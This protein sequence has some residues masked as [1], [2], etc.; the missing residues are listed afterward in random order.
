M[1]NLAWKT[2]NALSKVQKGRLKRTPK[3]TLALSDP[4]TLR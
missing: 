2:P 1:E 3:R 4:I